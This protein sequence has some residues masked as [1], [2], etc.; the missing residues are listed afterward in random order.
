MPSEDCET[1]GRWGSGRNAGQPSIGDLRPPPPYESLPA[2]GRTEEYSLTSW[3]QIS[4]GSSR[5]GKGLTP[6]SICTTRCAG[7]CPAAG[8]KGVCVP[9]AAQGRASLQ[10]A[11]RRAVS[12]GVLGRASLRCTCVR[13]HRVRVHVGREMQRT[14]A[15]EYCLLTLSR[16][17]SARISTGGGSGSLRWPGLHA[18]HPQCRDGLVATRPFARAALKS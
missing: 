9:R 13:V 11:M 3:L 12:A 10:A 15:S 7:P 2:P 16:S 1:N 18:L 6:S 17:L 5:A 4:R 8:R 14:Y